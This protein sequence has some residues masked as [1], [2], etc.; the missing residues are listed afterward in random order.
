MLYQNDRF[1]FDIWITVNIYA[2]ELTA[3]YVLYYIGTEIP[4]LAIISK[5]YVFEDFDVL[6]LD[7]QIPIHSL[8]CFDM[9]S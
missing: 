8:L 4:A 2:Q 9:H 5:L 1:Q 6:H 3:S 7:G